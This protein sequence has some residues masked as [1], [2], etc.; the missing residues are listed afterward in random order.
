[1][2]PHIDR[3]LVIRAILEQ[4]HISQRLWS[5]SRRYSR[6]IAASPGQEYHPSLGGE[7]KGNNITYVEY[8][9]SATAGSAQNH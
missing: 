8:Q 2:Y 1:M 6:S 4:E 7:E 9:R 3:I 5:H